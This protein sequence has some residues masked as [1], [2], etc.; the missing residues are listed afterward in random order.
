[1][2]DLETDGLYPITWDS[3]DGCD[4]SSLFGSPQDARGRGI[5]LTITR[6]GAAV[7]LSDERYHLYFLW[8]H[9]QQHTRGCVAMNAVD[10]SSGKFSVFFHAGMIGYEGEAACSVVLSWGDKTLATP[11][12][13]VRIDEALASTL[14]VEDGFT[15]FSEALK[16]YEAGTADLLSLVADL[17]TMRDSG[18]FDGKDW[19]DGTAGAQGPKGN[20]GAQG[21]AGSD[22]ADGKDGVSC[23]HS[24][25]GAVLTVTSTSGTSSADLRGPKGD[26][27]ETGATGVTGAKGNAFTYE[28]FTEEQLAAPKGPKGD[29]GD[30][31]EAAEIVGASA[32]VL[33]GSGDRRA[34]VTTQGTSQAYKLVFRFYNIEGEKGDALTF[35]DLTDEQ[36]AALEG[37]KGDQGEIGPQGPQGERGETG[38][39]GPQGETGAA[40]ADATIGT[41]SVAV[42]LGG[43]ASA[44]TFSFA[45]SGL[46]GEAG[47]TG[48]QGPQG[49][50]GADGT[51]FSP[52]SPLSLV[53]GTLSIDLSNYVTKEYLAETFPDPSEESY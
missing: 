17:T 37:E 8:L 44:R 48:A 16:A 28:D 29:K 14:A 2:A 31:G 26:K 30:A 4:C 35:D 47:A 12:F 39:Q 19:T 42:T 50:K 34:L 9:R 45:F 36:K 32:Y 6:D 33:S 1:M 27:G 5:L 24:W 41:P 18:E 13:S 23:T 21:P 51:T 15:L 53:D 10:A 7:D 38:P 46:K 49:E 40:G 43:T 25:D 11:T 52:A 3:C 20:T 22:G